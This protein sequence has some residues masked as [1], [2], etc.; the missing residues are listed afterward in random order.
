M[1]CVVIKHILT[2]RKIPLH[3]TL[4]KIWT[5]PPTFD[6]IETRHI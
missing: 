2:V 4:I 1:Y 6:E 5:G 3:L